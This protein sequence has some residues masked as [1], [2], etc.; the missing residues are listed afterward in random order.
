M[1][2]MDDNSERK[3]LK[4]K[5]DITTT[6]IKKEL[7]PNVNVTNRMGKRQSEIKTIKF[8]PKKA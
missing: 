8:I 2:S 3:P 5:I 1:R 7:S 6:L 4:F